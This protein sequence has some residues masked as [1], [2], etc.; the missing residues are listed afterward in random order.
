MGRVP[1]KKKRG[2][3]AWKPPAEKPEKQKQ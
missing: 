2:K 1:Q 3:A